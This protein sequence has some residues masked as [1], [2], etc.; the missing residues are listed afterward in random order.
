MTYSE[1]EKIFFIAKIFHS[2]IIGI[3]CGNFGFLNINYICFVLKLG[4]D[5]N[6]QNLYFYPWRGVN[7]ELCKTA[8]YVKTQKYA[9][10]AAN[11]S[12][13]ALEA[14]NRKCY[15]F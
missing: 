15:Y 9:R 3:F 5:C 6:F 7:A 1:L 10:L 12:R 2:A 11:A 8:N 13:S 14:L 4:I